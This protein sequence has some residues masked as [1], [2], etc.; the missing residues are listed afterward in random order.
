MNRRILALPIAGAVILSLAA[1]GESNTPAEPVFSQAQSATETTSTTVSQTQEST[2]ASG[3]ETTST[4]SESSSSVTQSGEQTKPDS[5]E[6]KSY[7]TPSGDPLQQPDGS[8]LI[9]E[10]PA[11]PGSADSFYTDIT[12]AED[13]GFSKLTIYVRNDGRNGNMQYVKGSEGD[14]TF[15]GNGLSGSEIKPFSAEVTPK[16]LDSN[17]EDIFDERRD[18]NITEG[19]Q[20][21]LDMQTGVKTVYADFTT[22]GEYILEISIR[23]PG[24]EPVV[25]RQP[26]I[27]AE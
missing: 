24:Y 25:I 6:N 1:C 18:I 9:S 23:Q 26:L 15:G 19:A 13:T 20:G 11:G 21:G 2:S 7:G 3:D 16:L 8:Y 22:A 12:P 4:D 10:D 27:V 17:G 5:D 14:I